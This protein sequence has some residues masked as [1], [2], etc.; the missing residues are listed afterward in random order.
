MNPVKGILNSLVVDSPL[1]SNL[2]YLWNFGS[3][4]GLALVIQII[5]GVFL[6]MHYVADTDLAFVSVEHIMRDTVNGW[7]LRYAHANGAGM[8][9]IAVY[10]HIG[11]GVYYGSY[12]KP[13]VLLWS[14]GVFILLI[15]MG[16]AFIGYEHSQRWFCIR[17]GILVGS[18]NKW[19]NENAKIST[20]KDEGPEEEKDEKRSKRLKDLIEELGINPVYAYE[21]LGLEE[22]RKELLRETRGLSGI[23]MILNKI[24]GDYYIGSGSTG[25]IYARMMSHLISFRGSKIVKLAVNKYGL[26]NMAFML[27][28]IYPE[29]VDRERN[30]E[31]IELEDK[32]LKRYLPNYNIL[33]KAG[34]SYG[35]KHT[36]LDRKKMKDIYSEER[37]EMIGKLNRGKKLSKETIEKIREKAIGRKKSD[38]TKKKCISNT[39]P[40]LLYNLNGTKYGEYDTIKEA[41]KA[42]N[43]SEKTI[44]RAMKTDKRLVKGKWKVE[45]V[46]KKFI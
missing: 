24:T 32:Y 26:K 28:E 42:I 4:L 19:P 8:F 25:R 31:L 33:T 43:C 3:I 12:R 30:R 16:T 9:F 22:T 44:R 2:T 45:D 46:Q 15:M 11:R 37:R 29:V 23:Y 1:P 21:N 13:R 10:I 34:S 40:V 14:V 35:Y 36:E 5:T 41:S 38:E 7:V 6:A 27:L 17:R 18:S 20:L 39:R